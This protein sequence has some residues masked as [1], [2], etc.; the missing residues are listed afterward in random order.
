MHFTTFVLKNLFRRPVRSA[1]TILGL[2]VAVGSM[3]ALPGIS[4]NIDAAVLKSLDARGVDLVV[5]SAGKTDQL[6]S[7][8]D[9]SLAEKARGIP[10]VIGVST[11]LVELVDLTRDSGATINVL[12]H[13]WTPDNFVFDDIKVTQGRKLEAGDRGRVMLGSK[14]AHENL[15]KS[16]GDTVTVLGETFEVVGIFESYIVYEDGSV[17]MPLKEVQRLASRPG[18]ITGFSVRVQKS[19]TDPDASVEAVRQQVLA[20]TDDKGRPAKLSAKPAPEYVGSVSHLKMVRAMA[21]IVSAIGM[22]IGVI[23]MLNTMIMSVL[24]RTQE[25]GILRAIGWPRSRVFRMIL[26]EAVLI[27]LAAAVLGAIGAT[28]TTYVLSQFPQV[29]GFIEGGIAWSVILEGTGLSVLIALVG[30]AYPAI[31]AARLLPT[32]A[33]RHE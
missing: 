21:W 31:R 2:A 27:S 24:E 10:G 18:K 30:G 25:I 23:S 8:L 12:L 3:I 22:L 7:D 13:G 11:A 20:L 14:L 4:H 5:T 19:P 6:T 1:L 17:A 28:A 9:E 26:T 16:V 33:I 29:N 32:E 15:N